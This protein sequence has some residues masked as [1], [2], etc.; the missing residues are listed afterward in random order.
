MTEEKNTKTIHGD[1]GLVV[2]R[3]AQELGEKVDQYIR[4][5][6]NEPE[7]TSHI[8]KMEQ[9][10]FSNGEGKIRLKE[11]VRGKDIFILCDVGNYSCTYKMF[12]F[13]NHMGPDE[14]FQD[15]CRAISAISGKA[16]RVTVVM[17]LLYASRQHKRA[18]RE[19]LD[20]AMALQEIERMGVKAIITFDAHD[21]TIQNAIALS[22]FES[23]YPTYTILKYFIQNEREQIDKDNMLV[24]SPDT[25]AMGRAIYYANVLGLDVGMFYKRR[26]YSVIINGKNPIIQHEYVG[27]DVEGKT[28]LIVDDMIASGES[29]IDIVHE[30][31]K[32]KAS[33]IYVASTFAFFT[34]GLE[35]F[36]ALYEEGALTRLYSTNL[37][38]LP[39]ALKQA[40]W[41]CEVDLSKF[42]AK[43]IS[44]LHK[45]ESI[46]PLLDAT[47]RL[48]RLIAEK[49][50]GKAE[51]MSF[52]TEAK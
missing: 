31:K 50:K 48:K 10:R 45:D 32:R 27:R 42:V 16:N 6:C 39:D 23:V 28:V 49:D 22:S 3:G 5:I 26:D 44:T 1:L 41:F 30:L 33:K 17:P 47:V 36:N 24:I 51:Q 35:K 37:S 29:V 7:G 18:G 2:L 38:Y 8:I 43:I 19:S 11:S 15:V 13:E 40:P 12:G 34:E 20:C 21:P 25:G 14:H 52:P 4:N 46:S 9:V